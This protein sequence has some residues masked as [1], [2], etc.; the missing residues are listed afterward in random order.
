MKDLT[1]FTFLILI[2]ISCNEDSHKKKADSLKG[3]ALNAIETKEFSSAINFATEALET[4][5]NIA[6]TIGAI[7]SNYLIARASALSGEFNNAVIYGE[8][9][10]ELCKIIK[11][12]PMEY[13][14]NNTLSWAYFTLGKGFDETLEHQKRQMFV[15]NQLGDDDAKAMVYNN[16]GYDATVS[17]TVPLTD[18]I[19]YMKFANDYYAQTEKNNGRWYT[20]MNLTWQ[21]RLI[22]D[23]PKSEEYGR[24]AVEQA[25]IDNDRHAIIEANT[26]LG[27]TLLTQNKIE[28]AKQFYESGLK[29]GKQKDDRDKYV[30]D[31][32]YSRY[33]WET[34]KKDEA[35]SLL[36]IAVSFLENSEI[37]YEMLARAFL[38]DYYFS[39]GNLREA[40]EQ[41]KKF[42]NPRAR[43][44]SQESDVIASAIEAQIAATQDLETALYILNNKILEI[45][46]SGS[47]LLKIKLI[48]LRD[49]LLKPAGS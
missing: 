12:Y 8:N 41:V 10:S 34:G 4:Y 22:N 24:M 36:K 49:Q 11:N 18:A 6:D 43:Y 48:E 26:N 42:K 35:I 32:Y 29:L 2:L 3:N 45:D 40:E 15:V 1:F 23:L 31:I 25:K 39:T 47:K 21:H 44:F 33:L 5:I 27:E 38:A 14:L 9:G 28:D 37:F 20:L 7:E 16:Y 17:G 13:K 19:E 46:K 30:F